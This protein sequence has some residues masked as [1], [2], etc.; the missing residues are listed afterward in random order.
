MTKRTA[1]ISLLALTALA[2]AVF[3]MTVRTEREPP[4]EPLAVRIEVLA[5]GQFGADGDDFDFHET[6]SSAEQRETGD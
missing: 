1:V 5:A 2:A 6:P 3:E 4:T